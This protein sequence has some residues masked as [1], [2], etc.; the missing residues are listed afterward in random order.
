MTRIENRKTVSQF[1]RHLKKRKVY[2]DFSK[3]YASEHRID[4][5]EFPEA[6]RERFEN[7]S[8]LSYVTR[9][10]D[11]YLTEGGN[12]FWAYESKVWIRELT[13]RKHWFRRLFGI[14]E[15]LLMKL[16]IKDVTRRK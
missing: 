12:A 7:I 10:F 3:C 14:S 1:F 5:R 9:A 4:V 8:S 2:E 13:E 6:F 15:N 16:T 11:W